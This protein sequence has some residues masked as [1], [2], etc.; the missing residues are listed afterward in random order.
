MVPDAVPLAKIHRHA[1]LI[2]PLK[3][4]TIQKWFRQHNHFKADYEKVCSS[5]TDFK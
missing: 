2:G 5:G 1:G 4:N 3:E